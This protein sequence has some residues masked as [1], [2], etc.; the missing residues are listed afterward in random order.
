MPAIPVHD[1]VIH[2]RENDL[3]VGTHGRGFYIADIS[4]LQEL[5][6]DV[7]DQEVYF[8]HLEPKVQWKIISQ[9]TRSAQ[10][11][12]GEN[13]SRGIVVYYYLKKR[14]AGEVK[15]AVYQGQKLLQEMTGS[16]EP[17]LNQVVWPGTFTVILTIGNKTWKRRA[18]VLKDHWIKDQQ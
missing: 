5:N 14:F 13:E 4:P 15:V 12:S 1:L 17:G 18:L 11:F 7:L 6:A 9:H 3:V 16:N 2:P 8:F 10:N